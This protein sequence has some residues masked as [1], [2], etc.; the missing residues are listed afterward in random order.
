[1]PGRPG[2]YRNFRGAACAALRLVD[3]TTA[4]NP[5]RKPPVLRWVGVRGGKGASLSGRARR[6]LFRAVLV[7][8]VPLRGAKRPVPALPGCWRRFLTDAQSRAKVQ[9]EAL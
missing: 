4:F 8:I 9:E 1:M 7:Q 5:T 3:V 6:L 2:G